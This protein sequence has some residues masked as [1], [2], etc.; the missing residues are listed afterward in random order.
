MK[1]DIP[2]TRQ[3]R[4]AI[5][6]S[7][8]LARFGCCY[9]LLLSCF[10]STITY[11]QTPSADCSSAGAQQFTVG[12]SV[13]FN[14]SAT[15]GSPALAT[16]TGG[17]GNDGWCWFTATADRTTITYSSASDPM[18]FVYNTPCTGSLVGCRD[19]GGSGTTEVLNIT[20]VSGTSYAVRIVNYNAG[21]MNGTLTIAN[22]ANLCA[23][24]ISLTVYGSCTNTLGTYGGA[25]LTTPATCTGT[26]SNDVWYKF[27]ANST[28]QTITVTP[29]S[30]DIVFQLF[31]GTCAS[32]VSRVCRDLGGAGT[33]E[34][35]T[36]AGLT[37][38]S[39]YYIRVMSY[40][41]APANPLFNICVYG[42]PS[43]PNCAIISSP[44]NGATNQ[45]PTT[46]TL[47]WTAGAAPAPTGY[48]VYF[49]TDAAATNIQNGLDVGNVLTWN[50]G[51]LT[52]NQLYYWKIVPYNACG[53]AAGPCTIWSFTT[54]TGGA[55]A[56]AG[57]ITG[58]TPVCQSSTGNPYSITALTN[59][60]SYAWSYTGTGHTINGSSNSVTIDFS[61]TATSGN[62]SV[63]GTNACGNGSASPNYAVTVNPASPP[64]P[65]SNT[66]SNLD[67]T[68]F[69][70]NWSASAGATGYR[71][72]VATDAGF[73]SFVSGYNNL[74]VGNVT[75][76]N[77]TG[78]ATGTKFYY[79]VR[80]YSSCGTSSNSG[81][82]PAFTKKYLFTVGSAQEYSTI[83]SA[84]D[85]VYICWTTTAFD[86]DVEV[87]VYNGTYTETVTTNSAL[88]PGV[89]GRLLI[90]AAS[91]QSPVIDGASTRARAFDISESYV[92]VSG[93]EVKN[94]TADGIK[95]AGGNNIITQNIVHDNTAYGILIY[96]GGN[97]NEV[98]YNKVYN[99]TS[100][101]GIKIIASSSG[102]I[103]HNLIYNNYQDGI[104]IGETSFAAN[105]ATVKNNTC[106]GNG[107]SIPGTEQTIWSE[108]FNGVTTP[109]LP[110]TMVI[111]NNGGNTT[112]TWFTTPNGTGGCACGSI[113]LSCYSDL[114]CQTLPSGWPDNITQDDRIRTVTINC[115]GYTGIKLSIKH[116]YD[117]YGT[118]TDAV[119]VEYR[120]STSGGFTTIQSY[121]ADRNAAAPAV[122]QYT[123]SAADNQS[124]V[125]FAFR[126]QGN[127]DYWWNIDDI[128][129]KGTPA[130]TY[131]GSGLYISAST[132]IVSTNN[133][134][135]AKASGDYYATYVDASSTLSTSSGWNNQYSSG[136][137]LCNYLGTDK[138]NL[139]DWNACAWS[140]SNDDINNDPKF[141]STSDFHL[142]S[143]VTN[144]TYVGGSWPPTTASGGS[145]TT[146]ANYSPSIDAGNTADSYSNEPSYNGNRINQGA[147][148]GTVQASKSRPDNN[149]KI[150]DPASQIATNAGDIPS[151]STASG[152]AVGVFKFKVR[153]LGATGDG[154][155]TLPT[156]IKITKVTGP[157]D[158][159]TMIAGAKLYN[160]GTS[161][162]VAGTSSVVNA[163]DITI[164]I[165]SGNLTVSNGGNVEVTLKIWLQ[166]T[167]T[168]NTNLQFRIT[169]TSHGCIADPS[170]STFTADFGAAVTSNIQAIRVT[171]TK[172]IFEANK[173]PATVPNN[174]TFVVKV[175]A[176][177]ANNNLDVDNTCLV[178]LVRG[179]VGTGTLQANGS[180]TLTQNLAGGFFEWSNILYTTVETF[181]IYASCPTI[182]GTSISINCIAPPGTFS[183]TAPLN[184]ANCPGNISITW[185]ASSGAT[186]YD[187]YWCSVANCDP[188]SGT[189]VNG[190]TSPYVFNASSG[191]TQ[192]RFKIRANNAAGFAWS[193]NAGA[194]TTWG[195]SGSFATW[196]GAVSTVWSNASNWC[197]S[198]P[199]SAIDVNIPGGAPRYPTL[200]A[201]AT[202]KNLTIE[203][204]GSLTC[205]AQTVNIYGNFTNNGTFTAGTG[206]VNFTG[207]ATP[208]TVNNG[209]SGSFNNFTVNKTSG[210]VVLQTNNAD[211][212]GNLTITAGTLDANNLNITVAG[213]WTNNATFTAGTGTVTF[214]GS[215]NAQMTSTTTST[216]LTIFSDGFESG[217]SGWTLGSVAN[218]TD[219][220]ICTGSAH[221][222]S[223]SLGAA[224][225]NG[226]VVEQSY[227]HNTNSANNAY[228]DVTREVDM[229]DYSQA[230]LGYWYKC[231]ASSVNE[232]SGMVKINGIDIIP[233]AEKQY[234]AVSGWTQQSDI[235]ISSYCGSKILLTFRFNLV[236]QGSSMYDP[237][238]VID[239]ILIHGK[240]N[241]ETFNNV[242]F[243]KTGGASV[244]INSNFLVNTDLNIDNGC[245]LNLNGKQMF[246]KHNFTNN[247]QFTAGTNSGV[248]FNGSSTQTIAGSQ[249]TTFYNLTKNTNA[250]LV[251]GDNTTASKTIEATNS[252]TWTNNFDKITVG[253]GQVTTFKIPN[254]LYIKQTCT[255]ITQNNSVVSTAGNYTDYGTYTANNGMI[256]MHGSSNASILR[257]PALTILNET[258]ETGTTGWTLGTVSGVS[259]W[260]WSTGLAHNSDYDCAIKDLSV[261]VPYD[262]LWNPASSNSVDLSRTINLAGYTAAELSFWWKCSGEPGADYGQVL[263]DAVVIMNNMNSQPIYT[264]SPRFDLSAYL[265]GTHTLTFR[266]KYNTSVGNSPGLCIDD[267]LITS[268][269]TNTETFN[270][271]T[272]EKTAA[273]GI[274]R[275]PI[276]VNGDVLISSGDF[277]SNGINFTVG[278]D[279]TGVGTSTF[280]HQ[281]NTVT[282]DGTGAQSIINGSSTSFYNVVVNKSGG[283][284]TLNTN[285]LKLDNNYTLTAGTFDANTQDIE[286]KG[287]WLNNGGTFNGQSK[288]VTF[289]GA[290]NQNITSNGATLNTFNSI[291]MEKNSGTIFL[292]DSLTMNGSLKLIKGTFDA[293][294]NNKCIRLK[295]DW[296]VG[297]G[298]T[299]GTFYPGTATVTFNGTGAQ[300]VNKT[301][302]GAFNL[303][304]FSFY[305]VR[306]DGSEVWFYLN[307]GSYKITMRDL[308]IISG[309]V[310]KIDGQP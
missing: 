218:H 188:I 255:L 193:S 153:D 97:S 135:Y 70:A 297:D 80:A 222:G 301:T 216:T 234:Y 127:N 131:T 143:D 134:F 122:D 51:A 182:N 227:W 126:Y 151:T 293:A 58:T 253:N 47:N 67:A 212:N 261:I 198:V 304:D 65:T 113:Y 257:E 99:T 130:P 205:G 40:G 254:D 101:T 165:P 280:T 178:T 146:Q 44:S 141:V 283:T 292:I 155:S 309:K 187:L 41:A 279:W 62:L 48:K 4:K 266:F 55:I 202:V 107:N 98:S 308:K 287:N 177:D 296:L 36:D 175:K 50:P 289:N 295:G 9:I 22:S 120:L 158:W 232:Y 262:Y 129:V 34:S 259:G 263:I 81:T 86:A 150:E 75:T 29:N 231:D 117:Y 35:Y 39:T 156:Q 82:Q 310:I 300:N 290:G 268:T 69:T 90:K 194:D 149:S 162:D 128:T 123:V 138:N 15:L 103:H 119:T 208:Q 43:T 157:A 108:N 166:T 136:S 109:N 204:G 14:V 306:I 203:T 59:A 118:A 241:K 167:V 148:G 64:V 89:S 184:A 32:L 160:N 19:A 242:Q 3:L 195:S 68:S 200:T 272:I 83:Q 1:P 180:P 219:W 96:G 154:I 251:I 171:A 94:H 305:D 114:T 288:T 284:A 277:K 190:V 88:V 226:G 92:T 172:L 26:G 192:Y 78:L 23:D 186:S 209:A 244:Q 237:G 285:T 93:F 274:L 179:S 21:A 307:S 213:N 221:G 77:V 174:N 303:H 42:T 278:T 30:D 49:G 214:D 233:N 91:G 294:T 176:V 299:Y 27:T 57:S 71:L 52:N 145:W 147:Y 276:D 245:T 74:D 10:V 38:N 206:T 281:N 223:K 211:I 20:T 5:Y 95:I 267:V 102:N 161:L 72:D 197:G 144:G 243:N 85:D 191:Q 159:S 106:Y 185:D 215:S 275:C 7:N 229:T 16:C 183:I 152:S 13:A 201:D 140:S 87:R 84:L 33:A 56:A 18:I 73:T 236:Y 46:T 53:N 163:S 258:F 270:D 282:F 225:L 132:G 239:D 139:T 260:V 8:G 230:W 31:S 76:K 137:K 17:T 54:G 298:A 252:F 217:N 240:L 286:I 28:S 265:G 170:G 249:N 79:R 235:D 37:C 133:I 199:T 63:Y 196:S 116:A 173:P 121:T 220:R 247:G 66:F 142:Q 264:E 105:S 291:S 273:S 164:T 25:T 125:Q 169:Q 207:T 11:S 168:D 189:I 2:I 61:G 256:K 124:V 238:F 45:C 111:D 269:S 248:T 302:A 271:L 228:I 250:D 6:Y 210:S 104:Q 110:A 115:S 181:N 224:K 12:T 60:S 246:C 24:A 100:G 112:A